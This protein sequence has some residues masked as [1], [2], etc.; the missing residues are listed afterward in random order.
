MDE[1]AHVLPC[2]GVMTIHCA[3]RLPRGLIRAGWT[4]A[5]VEEEAFCA[6]TEE[7]ESSYSGSSLVDPLSN[8]LDK[9]LVGRPQDG[10]ARVLNLQ[11]V[12][13]PLQAAFDGRFTRRHS[14]CDLL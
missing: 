1:V 6:P 14:R 13:D 2:C 10:F 11:L 12:H 9:V 5:V 8:L 7:G 3:D 4:T